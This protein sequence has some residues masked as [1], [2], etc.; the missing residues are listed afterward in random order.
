MVKDDLAG[1][2]VRGVVIGCPA[3]IEITS[4]RE[5]VVSYISMTEYETAGED[6]RREYND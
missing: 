6:V 5:G 2:P 4:I 3:G 1:H